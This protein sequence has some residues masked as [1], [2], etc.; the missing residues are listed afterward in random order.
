VDETS[1][2]VSLEAMACGTPVIAFRRGAIPEVVADGETGILV[3]TPEEMVQA[4]AQIER[5]DPR[6]CRERVQRLFSARR[7]ADEYAQLYSRVLGLWNTHH[8]DTATQSTAV[9]QYPQNCH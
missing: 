6:A 7:M 1:S 2:L 9:E 4:I 8:T 5:I 3:D